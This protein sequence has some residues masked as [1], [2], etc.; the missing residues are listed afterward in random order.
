MCRDKQVAHLELAFI[1]SNFVLHT[2]A[3]LET[4][5]F[6]AA[7]GLDK[8]FDTACMTLFHAVIDLP[9]PVCKSLQGIIEGLA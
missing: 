6:E 4:R 1:E 2:M 7:V 3:S 5:V 9:S 8:G